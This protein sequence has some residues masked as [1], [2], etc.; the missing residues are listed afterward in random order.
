M[1]SAA[2]TMSLQAALAPALDGG[3]ISVQVGSLNVTLQTRS[4]ECKHGSI[5]F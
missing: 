3:N 1:D 4:H 5:Q 2:L